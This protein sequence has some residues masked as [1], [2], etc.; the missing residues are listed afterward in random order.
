MQ[1]NSLTTEWKVSGIR[2]LF[3]II[4]LLLFCIIAVAVS[5]HQ[6]W[7]SVF[8]S[9]IINHVRAPE[10]NSYK[11]LGIFVT[12]TGNQTPAG[13]LTFAIVVIASIF[14]NYRYATFL[15]V[16]V[17]L[18]GGLGNSII[19]EIVKRPRPD[20]NPFLHLTSYSFPS[21]HSI[22]AMLTFGTLILLIRHLI[23]SKKIQIPLIFVLCIWILIIG[24]SRIYV[25]V[26][27]PSDVLAG[28][29]LGYFFLTLSQTFFYGIKWK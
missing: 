26:H 3:A 25:G 15:L 29:L 27:Y 21:G 12:K 24:M 28:F 18:L 23:R 9:W 8:D 11:Q 4:S 20:E 7:I 13:I 14:K 10:F 17:L 22:T 6:Y 16:N 2:W 19:K 1:S 5:K